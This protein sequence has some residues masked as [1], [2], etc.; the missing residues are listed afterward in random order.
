MTVVTQ[1]KRDA[2]QACVVNESNVK[3]MQE[4][5]E[6]ALKE[7]KEAPETISQSIKQI[8]QV[9]SSNVKTIEFI[10]DRASYLRHVIIANRNDSMLFVKELE[11]IRKKGLEHKDIYQKDIQQQKSDQQEKENELNIKISAAIHQL[12]G[13]R[14]LQELRIQLEQQTLAVKKL[15][16][17]EKVLN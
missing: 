15:I 8:H 12:K 2:E 17:E 1:I 4:K 7:S 3:H 5:F 11:N 14:F 10:Q 16:E 9:A 13:L 6:V